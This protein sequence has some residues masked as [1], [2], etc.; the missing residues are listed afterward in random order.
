MLTVGFSYL[1]RLLLFVILY[2]LFHNEAGGGS[3][4]RN[5]E[6]FDSDEATGAVRRMS[7]E[8][9]YLIGVFFLLLFFIVAAAFFI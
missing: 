1:F 3:L 4:G 6:Y 5:Y 9:Q 8:N 7:P 2:H